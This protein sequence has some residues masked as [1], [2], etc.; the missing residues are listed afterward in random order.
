MDKKGI[1]T[2]WRAA[3]PPQRRPFAT[4]GLSAAS[5]LIVMM[6]TQLKP[7]KGKKL[8]M[9]NRNLS[10]PGCCS[11]A[12]RPSVRFSLLLQGLL[13]FPNV[14]NRTKESSEKGN[15]VCKCVSVISISTGLAYFLCPGVGKMGWIKR[16]TMARL[17]QL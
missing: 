7:Q 12:S 16:N 1:V 11:C 9:K 6:P 13:H 4:A 17:Q 8:N 2:R 5:E 14:Q 15:K 10:R 3:S